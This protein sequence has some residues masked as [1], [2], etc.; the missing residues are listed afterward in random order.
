LSFV[1]KP[2]RNGVGAARLPDEFLEQFTNEMSALQGFLLQ[3]LAATIAN[4]KY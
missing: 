4:V 3:S 1:D 2:P